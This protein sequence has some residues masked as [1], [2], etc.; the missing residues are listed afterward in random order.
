[1]NRALKLGRRWLYIVHR[2]VGIASALLF[3]MWFASGLVMLYVPYPSL[4]ER[5]RRV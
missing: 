1:M 2:W 5:E 3:A 4:S